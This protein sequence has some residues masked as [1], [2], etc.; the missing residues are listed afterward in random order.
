MM[1][2]LYVYRGG[3]VPENQSDQN[4]RELWEWLDRM[5]ESGYEKVRFAGFGRKVVTQHAVTDYAGDLFGVSVIEADS[6][7]EAIKLTSDWP[8]LRYG[9]R[10]E[11]MEALDD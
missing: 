9:G 1:K 7:E 3:E 6:L 4:I 2:F 8:E 5:K 10:I 11:I